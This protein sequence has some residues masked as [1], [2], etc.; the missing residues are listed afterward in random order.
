LDG[1]DEAMIING[2]MSYLVPDLLRQFEE[3]GI[4]EEKIKKLLILH[5][6]FDHVGIVPFFKRRHQGLEI[7]ASS[8]AW[9]IL[10][11]QK[12]IDTINEFGQMVTEKMGLT[13]ACSEYDLDWR[14]D[15]SGISVAEGDRIP[16]GEVELHI[17]ETPGHSSCHISAYAPGLKV[18][19]PSD[20]G[21]IPYKETIIPAGNSNYTQFQQGL[22]KL[23]PLEFDYLCAEHYGYVTGEE[24][25]T[26]MARSI[27]MARERRASI[28]EAYRR[29]GNI[30]DTA[31]ELTDSFYAQNPNYL[32]PREIFEAVNRQMVR[33]IATVLEGGG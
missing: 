2:G 29:T 32:V 1:G 13:E 9:K 20:G 7:Y 16:L 21:G 27:E 23:K 19:F 8:R 30:D 4:D 6:H 24:A 12:A 14:D 28:E 33:H 17:I 3:F 15:V 31:K 18:L 11:T 5:S 22:E 25:I 10:G 26:Y